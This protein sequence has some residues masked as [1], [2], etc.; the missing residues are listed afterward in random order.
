MSCYHPLIAFPTDEETSSGKKKYR[1]EGNLD[2]LIAKELYPGS[3]PVPCGKCIGCRLDYSRSWADRMMLELETAG[4]GIFV[5]LTY[6]NA[7]V[8]GAQYI[9]FPEDGVYFPY[10]GC[11]RL[12]G[13]E[14]YWPTE[15][16]L[17][18]RDCQLFMKRLRKKFEGRRV[19]FY[20]AG[21]YGENTLRP[22]YHAIV[23]GLR[24]SDFPDLCEHGRNEL[25]Q[26]Y[27]FS[28]M[29]TE[30]WSLGFVLLS[31]VSWKTCAYVARYVTKKLN[32]P[33]SIEYAARNVI[34]EFS[35]M[36]RK[37]GIGRDYLDQH[38]DCLDMA[39]INLSTPEGGLKI[40]I[41]KYYYKQLEL[42]DPER[43]GKI[44][45]ER[46]QFAEDAMI[47]KLQKTGLSYLDYLETE[48]QNKLDSVKS[49][50]RGK[51]E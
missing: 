19:R 40:R 17:D 23:F 20:L 49:L 32:G 48:E 43:Y 46:K 26:K 7:H 18:K 45:S 13:D 22:H 12:I 15:F 25:G 41:P 28:P 47:L 9:D 50:K 27:Y 4:S 31:D 44:M 10:K 2:P 3:L 1:I 39:N 21:E 36:S 8:H 30:T 24:L 38:P 14:C 42:T 33:A 16:T 34:P 35:L 11:E 29:L 5:T 6:N 37:P 51:V